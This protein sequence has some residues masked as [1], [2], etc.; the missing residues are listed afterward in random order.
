VADP[1]L[2]KEAQEM[3]DYFERMNV[4]TAPGW[5]P[6]P[7]V[8]ERAT[9]IGLALREGTYGKT[10]EDRT[11]P[12]ITYKRKDGSTFAVH[13]FHQVLRD[14][15]AELQTDIGKEQYITYIGPKMGP[16]EDDPNKMEV[17]YHMY[18]AENVGDETTAQV[19][20]EEGFHF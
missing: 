10:V 7:G 8:T 3:E 12:V 14:R 11:Y 13:A 19:G 17:K 2:S 5:R 18:D 15:L 1:K 9:V 16:A 6:E 4:R 20:K